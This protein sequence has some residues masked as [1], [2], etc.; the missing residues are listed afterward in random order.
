MALQETR[1]FAVAGPLCIIAASR[2]D[3]F[4]GF[5]PST[6]QA[7][8]HVFFSHNAC[9]SDVS[10][11][12]ILLSLSNS[13]AGDLNGDCM[14]APARVFVPQQQRQPRLLQQQ[15][16]KRPASGGASS[17][18]HHAPPRRAFRP[19]SSSNSSSTFPS[20]GAASLRS[21]TKERSHADPS[22]S[23]GPTASST[24]SPVTASHSAVSTTSTRVAML[25]AAVEATSPSL[26]KQQQQQQQE[27]GRAISMRSAHAWVRRPA[28]TTVSMTTA[29]NSLKKAKTQRI[30]GGRLSDARVC[31]S[32]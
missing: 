31:G 29:V 12:S 2:S 4:C 8:E 1:W 25:Q 13:G 28:T 16:K 32:A 24:L 19:S 17:H 23:A 26:T 21:A 11:R 20:L 10:S 14:A 5:E 9:P 3:C 6:L 22:L 15:Q 30:R 7:R 27:G 18:S